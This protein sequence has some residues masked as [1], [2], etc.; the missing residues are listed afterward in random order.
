MQLVYGKT[1]LE[2]FGGNEGWLIHVDHGRHSEW[3]DEL[4]IVGNLMTG[5]PVRVGRNMTGN[6]LQE[7]ILRLR[8]FPGITDCPIFM[9]MNIRKCPDGIIS[10]NFAPLNPVILESRML[11]AADVQGNAMKIMNGALV[12]TFRNSHLAGLGDQMSRF[13][14]IFNQKLR[15]E[16]ER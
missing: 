1:L 5:F 14:E 15:E 10:Q 7:D 4:R 12:I 8:Q 13:R 3:G 9:E 16:Q 6:D 2:L 11:D